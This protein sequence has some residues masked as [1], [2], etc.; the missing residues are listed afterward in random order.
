MFAHASLSQDGLYL[1]GLWVGH[2]L[3]LL[4]MISK[5]PFCAYVVRQV[6]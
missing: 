6:P 1:K 3:A 5:E 2:P 4:S